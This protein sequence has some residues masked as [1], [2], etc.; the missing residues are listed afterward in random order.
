MGRVRGALGTLE[1][2]L[3]PVDAFRDLIDGEWD[4]GTKEFF[5][6]IPGLDR[7]HNALLKPCSAKGVAEEKGRGQKRTMEISSGTEDPEFSLRQCCP[8]PFLPLDGI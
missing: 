4:K 8:C 6:F 7:I 2:M 1:E 3:R 5:H